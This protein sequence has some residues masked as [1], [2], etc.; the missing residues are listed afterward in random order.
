MATT[1]QYLEQLVKDKEAIINSLKEKGIEVSDDATF[2]DLSSKVS[3]IPSGGDVNEYFAMEPQSSANNITFTANILKKIPDNIVLPNY[4]TSISSIFS[5]FKQLVNGPKI[6]TSKI[7]QFDMMF[8]MCDNLESVPNYDMSSAT[9]SYQMFSGCKKLKSIDNLNFSNVTTPH[10]MCKDCISLTEVNINSA[11]FKNLSYTF[12]GCF[13]LE[14]VN[15]I[16][17]TTNVTNFDHAIYNCGKLTSVE[18]LDTSSATKIDYMLE[19][20][21]SLETLQELDCS[22]VTSAISAL[23][24]CTKLKN[25]G[26][27]KNF[28][29]AYAGKT[30]SNY[31]VLDVRNCNEL[32]HDSLM[33]IINKVY[34]L[35]SAGF[36]EHAIQLGSTNLA[37]LTEDEIKIATDKGWKVI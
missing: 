27:F 9:S 30:S 29:M 28:G 10:Y 16:G 26:G 15:F 4:C 35:K 11:N 12:N 32:T 5:G 3:D 19:Y 18:G 37:K 17:G 24:G 20:C 21:S 36:N 8:Y 23:Y 2:S 34:D 13:K 14:K 22:K 33:N 7:K 1:A 6:D 31:T 25:F